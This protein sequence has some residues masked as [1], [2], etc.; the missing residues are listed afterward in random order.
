[1]DA[2]LWFYLII[3]AIYVLSRFLKSK[4]N[5]Q[6]ET[7]KTQPQR[8]ASPVGEKP[9][10]LTFEE[11]LREITETK[12]P[13]KPVLRPAP[14]Q[15][16]KDYDD[17]LGEEAK[18]LEDVNYDYRKKDKL[19]EEYEEARKKAFLRP[20]LEETMNVRDTD[21]QFRKFKVFEENQNKN[22]LEKFT[23]EFNDPEGLRKAVV[24]SEILNRRFQ[25]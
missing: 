10:A 3:G 21:V 2:K 12:Q 5:V 19:Y 7:P 18:S 20:S 17:N 22:L 8:N 25:Y 23:R 9:K 1:M 16:F 13:A 11:L 15:S 4:G 14:S 24:L 6:T